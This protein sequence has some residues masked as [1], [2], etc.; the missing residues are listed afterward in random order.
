MGQCLTCV[1]VSWD[2]LLYYHSTEDVNK[3]VVA[4]LYFHVEMSKKVDIDVDI[5]VDIFQSQNW[6]KLTKTVKTVVSQVIPV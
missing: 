1:S 3:T 5:H 4:Y 6:L 2:R